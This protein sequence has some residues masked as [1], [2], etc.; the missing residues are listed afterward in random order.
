MTIHR[1]SLYDDVTCLLR[2]MITDGELQPG[3]KIVESTLCERFSVSRTPL[4]EALKVLAAEGLV[5]LLPRR[6][7]VVAQI[8]AAEIEELFPVMGAL[9]ALAGKLALARITDTDIGK[10]SRLHDKMISSFRLGDEKSYIKINREIHETI[11]EISGN[12]TLMSM[13]QQLLGKTHLAR[14]L[15][16]KTQLQWERAIGDHVKIMAALERRDPDALGE[17]LYTHMV[18]TAAEIARTSVAAI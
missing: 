15:T 13:Y 10:L 5:H 4:R 11:L 12:S 16:R 17:I 8:T 18:E 3:E 1:R 7:A 2:S 14:F 6:G 9:E